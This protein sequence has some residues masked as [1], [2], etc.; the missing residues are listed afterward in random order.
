VEVVDERRMLGQEGVGSD[1]ERVLEQDDGGEL[2]GE[3]KVRYAGGSGSGLDAT[4]T[5]HGAVAA[6]EADGLPARSA[7]TCWR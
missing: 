6:V 3:D 5:L 1:V 2:R 7:A 4:R